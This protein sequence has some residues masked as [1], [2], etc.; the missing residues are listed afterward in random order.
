MM[1]KT[2]GCFAL[3][4][5]AYMVYDCKCSMVF[6]AVPWGWSALCD[7]GMSWSNSHIFFIS[8][9]LALISGSYAD[10]FAITCWLVSS[11][12]RHS[13]HVGSIVYSFK[14]PLYT[15]QMQMSV[16]SIRFKSLL[17]SVN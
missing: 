12:T 2:A 13:L 9:L 1:R 6:L 15:M 4:V 7:F 14:E 5:F 3:I 17:I 8:Q 10:N 16:S 11:A